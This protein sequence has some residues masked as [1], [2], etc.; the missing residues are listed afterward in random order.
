M[1]LEACQNK[2]SGAY[3]GIAAR[4]YDRYGVFSYRDRKFSCYD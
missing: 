2:D 3:R 1:A 4:E